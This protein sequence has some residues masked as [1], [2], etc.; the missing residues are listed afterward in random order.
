MNKLT[1]QGVQDFALTTDAL[2][3][4]QSAFESFEQLGFMGGD[5]I[6]VSGCVVTGSSV[7]SGWMFLKG[8]LMPFSGGSIQTNV[9]IVETV[10]NVT[11]D[12]ASREQRTYHAEFGTSADPNKNVAWTEIRKVKTIKALE[13]EDFKSIE[14]PLSLTDDYE[15]A[16]GGGL[17]QLLK[18]GNVVTLVVKSVRSKIGQTPSSPVLGVIPVNFL[19][20]TSTYAVMIQLD[21]MKPVAVYSDSGNISTI[22]VYAFSVFNFSATWVIQ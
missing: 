3:F 11:V 17:F 8:K 14:I 20:K 15:F 2:A 6:I 22:D 19:P 10:Q 13:D 7:S 4:M 1:L 18:N 12:I 9:R 5:N 21:N 16:P